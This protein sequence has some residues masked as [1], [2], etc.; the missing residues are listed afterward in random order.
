MGPKADRADR[1]RGKSGCSDISVR[2]NVQCKPR[3]IVS[4]IQTL[5]VDILGSKPASRARQGI[6][7]SGLKPVKAPQD[8]ADAP[9][10]PGHESRLSGDLVLSAALE[11]V[12][13]EGLEAL[14]MRRLGQKLGRDP[15]S[16]YRYAAN[17][18]AVLDGVTELVLNQLPAFRT[19][20]TRRPSPRASPRFPTARAA[21]PRC[22]APPGD[23]ASVPWRQSSPTRTAPLNSTR[24]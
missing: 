11:L 8:V 4:T 12:D 20:L 2:W 15:L 9:E 16:L 18:A 19:A 5:G 1:D 23:C 24:G 21:A 17:R 6:A 7:W 3:H 10:A 22:R 13:V 14:T